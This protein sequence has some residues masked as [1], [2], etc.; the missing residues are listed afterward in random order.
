VINLMD[1]LRASLKSGEKT[2]AKKAT[3]KRKAG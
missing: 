3:R 2:P 1:A